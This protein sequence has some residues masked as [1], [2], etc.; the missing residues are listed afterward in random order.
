MA[1]TPMS[2]LRNLSILARGSFFPPELIT[3]L[4]FLQFQTKGDSLNIKIPLQRILQAMERRDQFPNDPDPSL[5]RVGIVSKQSLLEH[6][7]Y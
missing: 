4:R 5:D 7:F 1:R 2:R 3:D 6:I